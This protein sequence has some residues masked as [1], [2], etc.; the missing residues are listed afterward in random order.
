MDNC[1][2]GAVHPSDQLPSRG[3]DHNESG[4]NT[5]IALPPE[6]N[7]AMLAKFQ[8]T[9]DGMITSE[10]WSPDGDLLALGRQARYVHGS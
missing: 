8:A 10:V 5:E 2:H 6:P 9:D 1:C 4:S 3:D 7:T